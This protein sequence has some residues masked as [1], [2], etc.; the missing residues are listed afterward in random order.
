VD[1]Y[2]Q[3]V[4]ELHSVIQQARQG[5]H[6]LLADG[7]DANISVPPS[8]ERLRGDFVTASTVSERARIFLDAVRSW[9]ASLANTFSDRVAEQ[10]V[11][12]DGPATRSSPGA[13]A[14]WSQY[15]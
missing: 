12:L 8:V 2:E 1:S 15:D 4:S 5:A 3:A 14:L 6:G 11:L 9:D 10:S 7:L 13:A